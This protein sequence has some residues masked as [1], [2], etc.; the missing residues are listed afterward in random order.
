MA[1][2]GTLA[3]VKTLLALQTLRLGRPLL[4]ED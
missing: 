1:K 4:F 2:E 3:D